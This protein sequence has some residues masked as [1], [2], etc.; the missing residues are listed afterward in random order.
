VDRGNQAAA[1]N[2]QKMAETD[3]RRLETAR[4]LQNAQK[5]SLSTARGQYETAI[6]TLAAEKSRHQSALAQ[7]GAMTA[8]EQA[9]LA[10]ILDKNDKQE[11]FSKAE[12]KFLKERNLLNDQ[13]TEQ[14][15]EKGDTAVGRRLAEVQGTQGGGTGVEGAQTAA[16]EAYASMNSA[17]AEVAKTTAEIAKQE[18]E[19]VGTL[20]RLQEAMQTVSDAAADKAGVQRQDINADSTAAVGQAGDGVASA[21]VELKDAMVAALDKVE[22]SIRDATEA[23][24]ARA[25]RGSA[26]SAV[27]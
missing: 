9:Q 21:T 13:V 17:S 7:V 27:S 20:Q 15:A 8:G 23:V 22:A 2:L 14:E 1:A 3:S 26:N 19:F 6:Q 5:E 24:A 18:K 4:A 25:S 12:I 16:D 10:R 11:K